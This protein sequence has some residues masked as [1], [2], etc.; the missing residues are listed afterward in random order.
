M[1]KLC[2]RLLPGG[3][4]RDT[5]YET[6]VRRHEIRLKF[7]SYQSVILFQHVLVLL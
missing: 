6:R 3:E 7:S 5:Q 2:L 4:L 1:P